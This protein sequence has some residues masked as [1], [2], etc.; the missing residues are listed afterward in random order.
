MTLSYLAKVTTCVLDSNGNGTAKIGPDASQYWL[1]TLVHVGT[2]STLSPV[3][4][5]SLHI[6][7][8]GALDFTTQIDF[9]FAGISDTTGLVSSHVIN[10]GIVITAQFLG[11]N[12]GDT[13]LLQVWGVSSDVP[14]AIGI[15][16]AFPGT[17]FSG[18]GKSVNI[19]GLPIP[20][21]ISGQPISVDIAAPDPRAL[22]AAHVAGFMGATIGAAGT[23]NLVP[24]TAGRQYY[25]H[26]LNL[27][28]DPLT[29][30]ATTI[31]V[32]TTGA[33]LLDA[34]R[35]AFWNSGAS[36]D[37]VVPPN[38]QHDYKGYAVTSGLGVQLVNSSGAAVNVYGSLYYNF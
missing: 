7:I 24:A 18:S 17:A 16:P 21:T 14:A 5:C 36:A 26:A 6:G 10:P 23:L 8:P 1:P 2:A 4:A 20:V 28:V 29:N 3:A 34:Y 15:T 9:T 35:Q 12:P 38:P 22:Y 30:S 27:F 37:V 11:G 33:S 19:N 32:Q 31:Q 25:L 13:A